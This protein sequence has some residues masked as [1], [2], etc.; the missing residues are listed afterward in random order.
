MVYNIKQNQEPRLWLLAKQ[1]LLFIL[2]YLNFFFFT[3]SIYK[4]T[5]Q[6]TEKNNIDAPYKRKP[7]HGT[8]ALEWFSLSRNV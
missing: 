4:K 3:F 7:L 6:V 1:S 2:F 5:A 8:L